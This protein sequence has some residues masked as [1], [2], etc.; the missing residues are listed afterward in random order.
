MVV[1]RFIILSIFHL[2]FPSSSLDRVCQD[3]TPKGVVSPFGSPFDH[4]TPS[5][6]MTTRSLPEIYS[7]PGIGVGHR[8][9]DYGS[10]LT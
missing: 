5:L 8:S 7:H 1:K 9:E 6:T 4:F 10:T 3:L 2:S